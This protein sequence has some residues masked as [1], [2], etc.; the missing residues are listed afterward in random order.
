MESNGT[1]SLKFASE[2]G[3]KK[4]NPETMRMGSDLTVPYVISCVRLSSVLLGFCGIR[5]TRTAPHVAC[6][7]WDGSATAKGTD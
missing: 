3:R 1:V 2:L 7:Q 4:R 6:E 5:R